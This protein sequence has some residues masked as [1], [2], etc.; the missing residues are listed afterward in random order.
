MFL[1]KVFIVR[2]GVQVL[3]H[4]FA[5]YKRIHFDSPCLRAFPTHWHIHLRAH[6]VAI[7]AGGHSISGNLFRIAI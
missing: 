6:D 4:I 5:K 7:S 3:L 2:V 1:V